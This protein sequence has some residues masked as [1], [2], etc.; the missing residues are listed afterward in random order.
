MDEFTVN[1]SCGLMM[2]LDKPLPPYKEV[3][4]I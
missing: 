3:L 2:I 4:T 1:E